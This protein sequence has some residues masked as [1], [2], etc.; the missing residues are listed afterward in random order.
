[1][2]NVPT[3][4][5]A[6]SIRVMILPNRSAMGTPRRR[7]PTNPRPSTPP[8][9]ST[10]SYA[11]RTSVRSISD[12]DMSCAF[13]RRPVLREG[14][15][16]FIVAFTSRNNGYPLYSTQQQRSSDTALIRCNSRIGIEQPSESDV[17]VFAGHHIC[18]D[19]LVRAAAVPHSHSARQDTGIFLQSFQ[20]NRVRSCS[21]AITRQNSNSLI[22]PPGLCGREH[23]DRESNNLFRANRLVCSTAPGERSPSHRAGLPYSNPMSEIK[24]FRCHDL[25]NPLAEGGRA[26]GV[27]RA[28]HNQEF[29]SAPAHQ[30]VRLTHHPAQP[31]RHSLQ[32]AIAGRMTMTIVHFLEEV[33][34]H[35]NEDQIAMVQLSN[36]A[37]AGSL[38]V[39]QNL[40]G[41][42]RKNFLEVAPVPHSGERICKG[43]LL[44]LEILALKFQAVPTQ[45]LLLA[46]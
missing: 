13:W 41:L 25:Q 35:H 11:R 26:G 29:F 36:I 32:Q 27:C 20:R 19:G 30:H 39:S 1:M 2:S 45:R 10:I 31:L 3:G 8:F 7:I 16:E 42:R 21:R 5:S 44:K 17:A 23:R 18:D 6:F 9:F 46:L 22:S 37:A 40:P 4:T 12:A 38:V 24:P 43:D 15:F 28:R 34:V 14:A 33:H